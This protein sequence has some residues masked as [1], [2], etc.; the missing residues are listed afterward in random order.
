MKLYIALVVVLSAVILGGCAS[1]ET[2]VQGGRF[3]IPEKD[4]PPR[5]ADLQKIINDAPDHGVVVIPLGRYELSSPLTIQGRKN[6]H[7]AFTPGTQVRGTNVNE[8]VVSILDSQDITLT[9][10][11]ARHVK[12]LPTYNCHGPVLQIKDSRNVRV[13]NCELNGCGAIGVSARSSTLTIRNCHVHHNTFNAF[14]FN[15]CDEVS[16]IGNIIENNANTIQAYRCGEILCSDNL[17]RD[18]GGYW[19]ES[20]EPGITARPQQPTTQPAE[21]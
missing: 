16:V 14:Y 1:P 21:K 11:R 4:L 12:P 17:V 19:E 15:S 13:E 2:D 8:A 6:L 10:I 18:N 7:I 20:R 3:E 9:G 5:S